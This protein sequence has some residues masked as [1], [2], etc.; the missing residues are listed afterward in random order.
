[1]INKVILLGNIGQDPETRN[2]P[3]GWMATNASLATTRIWKDK[4]GNQQ[5][6]TEWHRI[7]FYGKLAEISSQFLK[8]GSKI[9][10]EGRIKTNKWKD[11]EGNNHQITEII[12]EQMTMIGDRQQDTQNHKQQNYQPTNQ[13]IDELPF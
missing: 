5:K 13:E 3:N 4:Q 10:V 6:E 7:I 9:F 11:K 8:K 12:V 1:M 2:L